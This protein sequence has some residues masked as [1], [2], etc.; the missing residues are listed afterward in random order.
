MGYPLPIVHGA[1]RRSTRE[2]AAAAR[3]MRSSQ[4]ISRRLVNAPIGNG[5]T[6]DV[7]LGSLQAVFLAT[8]PG[9]AG[10]VGIVL[11][12]ARLRAVLQ[13]I[14]YCSILDML[15]CGIHDLLLIFRIHCL[16]FLFAFHF[17]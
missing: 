14:G 2:G 10:A 4:C 13:A 16:S 12:G 6:L 9:L 15:C 7:G 11:M 8:R 3:P 1:M 5:G 17:L